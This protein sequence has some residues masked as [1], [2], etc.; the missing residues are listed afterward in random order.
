MPAGQVVGD[1]PAAIPRR[2]AAC[3]APAAAFVEVGQALMRIR[4][5]GR[6]RRPTEK[7]SGGNLSKKERHE[8]RALYTHANI[9][10]TCL[11]AKVT[12]RA[13]ILIAIE[14]AKLA[15]GCHGWHRTGDQAPLRHA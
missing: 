6:R 11:T 7:V 13:K 9:V 14:R 8:F 10:E 1:S 4:D 3:R 5:E 15:D 12:A 2:R